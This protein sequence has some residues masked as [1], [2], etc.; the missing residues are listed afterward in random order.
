ML[1]RFVR[2]E[3]A[4]L[5]SRNSKATPPML[6]YLVICPPAIP[7]EL[8]HS[9]QIDPTPKCVKQD[10]MRQEQRKEGPSIQQRDGAEAA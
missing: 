2:D 10:A 4:R 3:I 7:T 6:D 1:R 8:S 5:V 9:R